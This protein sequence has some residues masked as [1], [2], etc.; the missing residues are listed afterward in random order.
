MRRRILRTA[1]FAAL[2]FAYGLTLALLAWTISPFE[3][4]PYDDPYLLGQPRT[5]VFSSPIVWSDGRVVFLGTIAQWT[6]VGVLLA[7]A[8]NRWVRILLILALSAHYSG[9]LLLLPLQPYSTWPS[10]VWEWEEKPVTI[11]V[12]LA[13]YL[14]G[15][16]GICLRL[17]RAAWRSSATEPRRTWRQFGL[18]T[19]LLVPAILAMPLGW[20]AVEIRKARDREVAVAVFERLEGELELARLPVPAWIRRLAGECFLGYP[21]WLRCR[22]PDLTDADLA[23]AGRL[24]ELI[25]L[26]IPNAQITDAGLAHLENLTLIESLC[27]SGTRI[28]GPGLAHLKRMTWLEILDLRD[29]QVDDDGLARLTGLQ[30]LWALDLANTRV[31]DEGLQHLERMESL[32]SLSLEG[33]QITDVGFQRLSKHVAWQHLSLANTP[34]TDTGLKYIA[35]KISPVELDLSNTD[36]TD[37]GLAHLQACRGLELLLL[38]GT[39]ITDTGLDQLHNL[40]HLSEL[41]VAN[42]SVT[43]EGIDRLCEA[44]PYLNIHQ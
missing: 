33:T 16:L 42:T 27:L 14:A 41:H 11:V 30:R 8:G 9:F 23:H 17:A 4:F 2:G 12:S 13:V 34:I 28:R 19:L 32:N 44:R 6:L 40:P 3:W 22:S 20:L 31:S 21:G 25:V 15:Q 10:F 37:A 1:L 39:A 7:A 43:Q 38:E 29:T 18:T 24:R 36:V 5:G 26:K 35:Q